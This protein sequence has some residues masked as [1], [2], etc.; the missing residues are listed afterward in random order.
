M[1]NKDICLSAPL[2]HKDFK[3]Q[4]LLDYK[5][6]VLSRECSI[7][8]R[9]E[10]LT[11]KAKFGIFGDGKELPQI[12]L[13][14]F[15]K[16]G[17]FRS[18]YYRDQTILLAQGHITVKDIFS[19]LYANTDKNI[20]PMSGGRQMGGHFV[21]RSID[22]NGDFLDLIKQL[23]HSSDISPVAGQMP[24]LIGLGQASKLYRKL[25]IKNSEKFSINGNEIAWGT[26][27]NAST[28]EGLFFESVNAAG[29]LQIPVIISVWDDEYGISVDN[30]LQT[31][32]ESISDAL[33]GFQRNNNLNG[34]EILTVKGWDYSALIETYSY[35]EKLARVNHVPV[36]IHVTELTQPLGHSSSGSHQRYKSDERLNWEKENDCNLKMREWIISSGISDENTLIKIEKDSKLEVKND[37]ILAW[38]LYQKPLLKYK[39]QLKIFL[40]ELIPITDNNVTIRDFFKKTLILEEPTYKDIFEISRKSFRVLSKFKHSKINSF[41]KWFIDLK[42]EIKPKYSSHLYSQSKYK[43]SNIAAVSAKYSDIENLVDGRI[44]IR[45]NFDALLSKHDRLIIFGQDIGVIG[46]VNQGLEG[47]QKKHGSSRV[48]DTG[49]R[50]ATIIGQGI[51]LSL[52]G[53]RPIAEIQYLDY[54]LYCIST[55]SDDLST[56]H[57]RTLGKQSVPLIIRTRGHRL[58]GIWHSG[59]PLGGMINLLRGINILVPRNMTQAAGFYNT[60]MEGDEP[61]IV[62]EPLNAYRLKE[63]LPINLGEFKIKIGFV[64]TLLIGSDITIVSY[65]STLRI[66]EEVTKEL[67]QFDIN[68]EIIDIQSLLPFDINQDIKKSVEKTGRILIVDEDV[69]GGSSGYILQQLID[70]QN[71]FNLLDSPPFTIS[72]KEHRPAYGT[73]GDYFSK[74]SAEDIFEKVY[75]IMRDVNPNKFPNLY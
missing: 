8:G 68:S 70:K 10:V 72:A 17:D 24:R 49:I 36:L 61:G 67:I 20:E 41:T 15:F 62:I 4:I 23:N 44:I 43:L 25:K 54:I 65:G 12:V 19:A 39:N 46:D 63:K 26:I 57:Y 5:T 64:E 30:K 45:D 53:F 9:R 38:E 21:T 34:F 42:S 50:E 16:N 18:G 13:N 69:P 75:S 1:S 29:V 27:G 35:A 37:R 55:L 3:S 48:S 7:L 6:M 40:K 31:T 52:R 74:P 14:R 51:G 59:S 11:G 66:V 56:Y 2:S 60:L 73:D 71:I 47:I 33:S 58:E 28:T 22:K 32:K